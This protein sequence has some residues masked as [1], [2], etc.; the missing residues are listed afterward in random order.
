MCEELQKGKGQRTILYID[1]SGHKV[2]TAHGERLT[3]WAPSH[4]VDLLRGGASHE[5]DS[6]ELFFKLVVL[7]LEVA[8]RIAKAGAAAIAGYPE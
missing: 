5:L 6:P 7:V 2:G 4:V 1:D 3:I 8:V